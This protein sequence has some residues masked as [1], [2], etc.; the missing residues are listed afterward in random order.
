VNISGTTGRVSSVTNKKNGLTVAVDQNLLRYTSQHSGAYAFGPTGPAVPVNTQ[1]PT[2]QMTAGAVFSQVYQ[3]FAGS[4]AKQ[5]VRLYNG[6]GDADVENHVEFSF[7]LGPLPSH[8]EIVTRFSSNINNGPNFSV[9]ANGYQYL[10]RIYQWS[11]GIE[12]NYYPMVYGSFIKDNFAQLSLIAERSHGSSSVASGQLEVMVHRN[13]DMGDGFGPGLTDDT[14]VYPSLRVLV[15]QP[16]SSMAHVHKQSYLMNFPVGLFSA[17]TASI[18]AWRT[19]YVTQGKFFGKDLPPNLHVQGLNP[20]DAS[21]KKAILRLVHLF[22]NGEDTV[23]SQPVTINVADYFV[24]F[25]IKSFSETTL[26]ANKVLN[27]SPMTIQI[28]PSEIRTFVVEFA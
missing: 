9:D 17:T 12:S 11:S 5:T 27:P 26:S 28:A 15:D 2:T 13:P 14:E 16:T 24:G 25:N 22:A 8:A 3:V 6:N 1:A 18:N 20:L 4:Y 10:E 21:S 7:D 19:S 23:L